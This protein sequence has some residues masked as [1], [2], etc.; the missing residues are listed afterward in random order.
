MLTARRNSRGNCRECFGG[1]V[2][3]SF[4]FNFPR[5]KKSSACGT[6]IR[7]KGNFGIQTARTV[8][9]VMFVMQNKLWKV[10]GRSSRV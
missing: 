9:V 5:R 7:A 8:F 2:G 6:Q 1:I 10:G 3:A 4:L